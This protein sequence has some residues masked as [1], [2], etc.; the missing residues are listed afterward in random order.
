M[1]CKFY[2]EAVAVRT[3]K[4]LLLGATS[5]HLLLGC[6]L[7]AHREVVVGGLQPESTVIIAFPI[8]PTTNIYNLHINSN[9]SGV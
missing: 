3:G 9:L 5:E 6:A 7:L 8:F 1:L 2:D 4:N